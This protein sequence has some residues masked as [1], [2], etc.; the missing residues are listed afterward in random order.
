MAKA[1]IQTPEGI[2]IKLEG[3]PDEIAA[4]LNEIKGRSKTEPTGT[5]TK[6]RSKSN[7][8]TVP[9]LMEELR[10][11]GFFKK[12]KTMAEVKQRLADMGHIYPSTALSGPLRG[13]VRKRRLRRFKE[14]SEYVYAQ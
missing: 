7:R 3:A 1:Q 6:S 8:V 9:S 11:Q 12:G 13:E 10:N 2:N 5:K 14:N 4:V